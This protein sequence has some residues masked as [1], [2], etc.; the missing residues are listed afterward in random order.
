MGMFDAPKFLTAK[1]AGKG[2]VEAGDTFWLHNARVE[3]DGKAKLRVSHTRDGDAEIVFSSG[4]G[5]VGQVSRMDESDRGALPIEVRLDQVPS[6]KGSPTY[7]LTPS[8]LPAPSRSGI[9]GE[10]EADF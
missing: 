5:I 8:N 3:P 6:G 7:V 9:T 2:Y 4:K 10:P 1:E